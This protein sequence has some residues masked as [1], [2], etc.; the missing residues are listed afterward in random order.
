MVSTSVMTVE[1]M[2]DARKEGIDMV[3]LIGNPTNPKLEDR[4][5]LVGRVLSSSKLLGKAK[6]YN[7]ALFKALKDKLPRHGYESRRFGGSS[8]KA[9]YDQDLFNFLSNAGTTCRKGIGT[10]LEQSP[11]GRNW[12]FVYRSAYSQVFK[13]VRYSPPVPGGQI[14]PHLI[15]WFSNTTGFR[16]LYAS[17]KS[18]LPLLLAEVNEKAGRD[19]A[20]AKTAIDDELR[21]IRAAFQQ[22]NEEGVSFEEVIV[23][24]HTITLLL[25]AVRLHRDKANESVKR[26]DRDYSFLE[27]KFVFEVPSET[28][29]LRKMKSPVARLRGGAGRRIAAV[30]IASHTRK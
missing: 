27:Y 22:A 20:F 28:G 14:D 24:K 1:Q 8:G 29:R 9:R 10:I 4:F 3:C 15:S 7:S 23:R 26:G 6:F 17:A 18:R 21:S 16:E 13:R 19:F 11:D 2:D 12:F 25:S 30:A 5:L